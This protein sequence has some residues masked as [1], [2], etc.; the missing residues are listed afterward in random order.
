[1]GKWINIAKMIRT[2]LGIT[3]EGAIEM[4]RELK[5]AYESDGRVM[6]LL[7]IAKKLEGLSRHA[8]TH[9]AG[10]RDF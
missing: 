10:S 2:V 5:R 8:S 6:E 9:A 7:D 4:N 1:M 3:L